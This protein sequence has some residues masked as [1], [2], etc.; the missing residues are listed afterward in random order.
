MSSSYHIESKTFTEA[1]CTNDIHI[2]E[3]FIAATNFKAL[4]VVSFQTK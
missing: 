1:S 3:K 2:G 4:W